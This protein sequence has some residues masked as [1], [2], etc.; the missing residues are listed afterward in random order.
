[1]LP[2]GLHQREKAHDAE[3]RRFTFACAALGSFLSDGAWGFPVG[4]KIE[5]NPDVSSSL[6]LNPAQAAEKTICLLA[7]QL[8][9]E[10]TAIS[11]EE[12][13]IMFGQVVC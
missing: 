6:K 1:M 12:P 3:D 11:A 13:H 9:A 7:V 10:C 4:R 2:L 8:S 5:D